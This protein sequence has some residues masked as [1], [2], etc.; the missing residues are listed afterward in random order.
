MEDL[1]CAGCYAQCCLS[2]HHCPVISHVDL[3]ADSWA[4]L[5]TSPVT[6]LVVHSLPW[7]EQ[8]LK[9]AW[10][11]PLLTCPDLLRCCPV[12]AEWAA[13]ACLSTPELQPHL[14]PC[15]SAWNTLLPVSIHVLVSTSSAQPP[16]H[17]SLN[18]AL[19]LISLIPQAFGFRSLTRVGLLCC[20]PSCVSST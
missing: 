10:V 2:C 8:Y 19:E 20:D 12:N 11:R 14:C 4:G 13:P 17:L 5:P 9:Y 15:P 7:L 3:V 6:P 16:S 18:R 1:C